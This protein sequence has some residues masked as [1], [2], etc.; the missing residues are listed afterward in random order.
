MYSCRSLGS[1][2]AM[3]FVESSTYC[4]MWWNILDMLNGRVLPKSG[5]MI[6]E[7]TSLYKSGIS[8]QYSTYKMEDSLL[9]WS[10]EQ[11]MDE[12]VSEVNP[13]ISTY[14][15]LFDCMDFMSKF[16]FPSMP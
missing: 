3:T 4:V 11:F 13:S 2:E 14:C 10:T 9:P 8:L 1:F 15:V 6:C 7:P 16:S 5:A 12:M